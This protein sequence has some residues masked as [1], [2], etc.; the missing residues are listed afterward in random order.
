MIIMSDNI[1]LNATLEKPDG[2]DRCPL[3]IIIHGFT[4]NSEEPHLLAVAETMR[5]NGIATLRVDMYGHGKSGGSFEKH[6]LY[7]WLNNGMDVI[8]YAKS[9]DF[10]TDIY[11]CGHSQG[12]LLVMLLGCMERDIIKYI[13]PLSPAVIIPKQARKGTMLGINYDP[14]NLPPSI[15]VWNGLNLDS[16][17]IRVARAIDVESAIQLFNGRVFIAIGSQ[18]ATIPPQTAKAVA[19]RYHNCTFVEV[20]G[21]THC[22]DNNLS[23]LTEELDKYLKSL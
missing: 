5:R 22:Y 12:G 11:L 16:N 2:I 14:V 15:P 8:D 3:C 10:V 4:G 17:Y 18:D 23:Y 1:E 21:D 6:T 20:P 7:K 9:L 19:A 13:F